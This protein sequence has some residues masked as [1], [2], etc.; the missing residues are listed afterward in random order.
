MND[1]RW[2]L[3]TGIEEVLPARAAELERLRRCLL[4]LFRS[5]G[6]ELV[7]PPF[8]DYLE[9]LLTG[10]GR[11]LD[12]Q[13]FK[14]TDQLSGRLLG[15]R[16]D[17]T[18]QVARIDAHHLRREI[19]TRLCYLGTI[20]HTRTDGFAG[21]RSPL[22]IGAEIYGHDGPES[23]VEV[24]RL[25]VR[26]LETAGIESPY[27]DLG[28]VGVYRGLIQQAGLSRA[29]ELRL[30]DALQR[31]A[32]A[33]IDA[34]ITETGVAGPVGTMLLSLVELNGEDAL[35]RASTMLRAAD[36]QVLG[37]LDRLQ[38]VADELRRWLP[39][40]PVHFDLAELRGYTYK[41]GVV[42]AAF[43][44]GWGLEIA[45]GGRYDDIGRVF[46]RAR[47]AVGFSSDLKG[48]IALSAQAAAAEVAPA[49]VMAPWDADPELQPIVERLRAEGRQ[50][51]YELPDQ[52]G[53]PSDYNCCERLAK[54]DG[55]WQL[56]PDVAA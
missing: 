27:L 56:V 9:S 46:G 36:P 12:L 35:S 22:Q 18:P 10:T 2:L 26:T 32:S 40:L 14:L 54:I 41:T 13:T 48:L 52:R 5:W 16:A 38:R 51:L 43:A 19:P 37:A 20:L 34:I 7:I 28:H 4:D 8:I 3:P 24:L 53:V 55:V 23:D 29:D 44:P 49:A 30:F 47:P 39:D 31:K 33:E 6:Y 17:M 25:L 11:D 21:T 50:V 42:F 1:E 45:R 15:V